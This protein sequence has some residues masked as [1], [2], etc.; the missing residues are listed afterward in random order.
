[1]LF[2]SLADLGVKPTTSLAAFDKARFFS[3]LS[4]ASENRVPTSQASSGGSGGKPTP[5]SDSDKPPPPPPPRDDEPVP[6]P[7]APAN[8]EPIA[9]IERLQRDLSAVTQERDQLRKI[10]ANQQEQ[11]QQATP[12]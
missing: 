3:P 9:T 10:I 4:S 5:S 11:Q 8:Q 2:R 6:L 7:V 1:M 12:P